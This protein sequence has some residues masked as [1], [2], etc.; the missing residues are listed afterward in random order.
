MATDKANSYME[1]KK[2]LRKSSNESITNYRYNMVVYALNNSI[3]AAA[4]EYKTTRV[5]VQKWVKIFKADGRD[6]LSNKSRMGQYHPATTSPDVIDMI[7]KKRG[8]GRLGADFIKDALGLQCSAKTIHKYLKRNGKVKKTKTK[9]KKKR[10]MTAMRNKIRVIEKLQVDVKYLTDIPNLLMGIKFYNFPKFQITC[11]DY[12]SGDTFIPY[13]YSND[14]TNAAIF[15]A[16]V[17]YILISAGINIKKIHFQFDNGSEFR[18]TLKKYGLSLVEEI[19]TKHG[20]K[21][22]FNPPASPKYNSDVESF[23][24]T[25]E[26]ELYDYMECDDLDDFMMQAW[27]Y[28]IWYNTYRKNRNKNRMSPQEIL[29]EQKIQNFDILTSVPPILLDKYVDSL[30]WIK[31][32]VYLKW[33]TPIFSHFSA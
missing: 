23:H 14:S 16:Y 28:I 15:V 7:I 30:E 27:L 33:S 19:L 2:I 20:I 21:W 9:T 31:Q 8:K 25:I 26:R 5:T 29:R 4:R 18:N 12:K 13:S 10:D 32:G 11:R 1:N 6:A 17:I 22:K 3:S 24:G